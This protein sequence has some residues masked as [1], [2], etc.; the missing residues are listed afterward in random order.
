MARHPH[1]DSVLTGT[2]FCPLPFLQTSQ[3]RSDE[4][5]GLKALFERVFYGRSAS[6]EA[7]EALARI[8]FPGKKPSAGSVHRGSDR[9]RYILLNRG[10]TGIGKTRIFRQF[11]E[12]AAEQRIPVYEIHCYDV[13]GIPLKPFL[14]VIRE[15]LLDRSLEETLKE[16]YRHALEHVL[17]EWYTTSKEPDRAASIDPSQA[18]SAAGPLVARVAS[19][20]GRAA[21]VEEAAAEKIRVFDS[22]TQ[23]LFEITVER[24]VVILIHDLHWGDQVTIELL[25]YIGRNLELRNARGSF[26]PEAGAS[27]LAS[28]KAGWGVASD[29]RSHGA[30]ARHRDEAPELGDVRPVQLM[31]LANYTGFADEAH[32]PERSLRSLGEE[33]FAFHGEVRTLSPEESQRFLR[34]SLDGAP[35]GLTRI[36]CDAEGAEAAYRLTQGFPS[37]LHELLR[38]LFVPG[39]PRGKASVVRAAPDEPITALT[40]AVL[41]QAVGSGA[42]P[43]GAPERWRILNRRLESLGAEEIEL[44]EILSLARKPLPIESLS[45]VITRL[46][47]REAPA[48]LEQL[49]AVVAS[50]EEKFFLERVRHEFPL[51]GEDA[52]YYFRMADYALLLAS[53]IDAERTASIQQCLGEHCRDLLAAQGDEGA[54]EIFH[55]LIRGRRPVDA[56][57]FGIQAVERFTRA[58]SP[59]KAVLACDEILAVLNESPPRRTE[60]PVAAGAVGI[61]GPERFRSLRLVLERKSDLHLRLR[62]YAAAEKALVQLLGEEDEIL[63][64]HERVEVLLAQAEVVRAAGDPGRSLKLLSKAMRLHQNGDPDLSLRIHRELALASLDRQDPKRAVNFCLNGL[65]VAQKSPGLAAHASV[66]AILSRAH[67]QRGDMAHAV[68]NLHRALETLE[69]SGMDKH[70]TVEVLDDLGRVYLERGNYFRA[71]RYL[72]KS[73]EIKRRELDIIGL[74]RSYDELGKVYLRTDDELKT[75]EHLHRSLALK[76]RVGDVAGM[77]PT[78]GVLGELYFRLGQHQVALRYFK[79]EVENS[80]TLVDT[81]ALLDAFLHMGWV[82][83]ELGDLKQVEPL[84]RQV[85]ILAGE[86]KCKA[87]EA[88]GSRLRGAFEAIGRNWIESEKQLRAAIDGHARL[89]DRRREALSLLGLAEVKFYREAFD[90]SLKLA[91]KAQVIAEAQKAI[92]LQ[93][94]ALVMKGNVYRFLKGGSV[95]KAKEFLRRALELS[96]GLNDVR[97]LF[98]IFYSLAKVYHYDREFTEAGSFYAKAE[99]LLRRVAGGLDEDAAA[100]FLDDRRRKL[101]FE[102][103]ARFRKEAQSRSAPSGAVSLRDR[104]ATIDLNEK[105]AGLPDYKE[106]TTR[107]LKLHASVHALDFGERALAEALE[108]L[109]AE[110]GLLV[111]VQNRRFQVVAATGFG[112]DAASHGEFPAAQSLAEEAIRRGRVILQAGEDDEQPLDRPE[113]QRGGRYGRSLRVAG[114]LRRAI[115]VAPLSTADRIFGSIYVDRGETVGEFS[116]RDVVMAEGFAAHAGAAL[117]NRRLYEVAIREPVTGF[118][119]PSYFLDLLREAMRS[120]NLQSTGFHILGFHL[121]TLEGS[122]GQRAGGLWP[123][124]AEELAACL[125]H[126]SAVGWWAPIL[127]VLVPEP[128]APVVERVQ[129]QALQRL[130]ALLEGQV[131]SVQLAPE[132]RF[133][134]GASL[135]QELRSRLL[136]EEC[137]EETIGEIRNLLAKD[138]L[139]LKEAKKILEKHIIEST[140]RRTG[141]NITHAA[142]EL[143]IHRPQLSNLLKKYA[144]KREVFEREDMPL[145]PIDN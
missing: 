48:S 37:Y 60:R 128:N 103:A 76:E 77:N 18:A 19:V 29:E 142:R 28:A 5:I 20:V 78:L 32:Y 45:R 114:P 64:A 17:P 140:M 95:E 100:Q 44:L 81:R 121:P 8:E 104:P 59:E 82:Y 96:G 73:L 24:P 99:A 1:D 58:F 111:R 22:L 40:P 12:A 69:R 10:E 42:L 130:E 135:Y 2:S 25:R 13:E 112:A 63:S 55:H 133:A 36:A 86:F 65:K 62:E 118:F 35:E 61:V 79:R 23:L 90:E 138:N 72:Y 70:A 144:L 27:R 113:S 47:E 132:A 15:I 127:S 125:P 102:D 119:T 91:S 43:A 30:P 108:L 101:F 67:H 126:G 31:I 109:K 33:S 123:K 145:N 136:P 87:Q 83:L 53:R 134:D 129:A 4:E 124:V 88:E 57:R 94:L 56:I 3:F 137:D 34:H 110:R 74:A 122:L 85:S 115:L 80:Q 16:K 97:L 6:P 66:L 46:H 92:D 7:A 14:R 68:D 9:P 39:S 41:E 107:V 139:T 75:L 84:C 117:E 106:L 26:S 52:G 116:S 98:D 51:R 131:P 50:L 93:A 38:A 54:Y 21:P 143:G 49:E 11:R 120:S 89:S 105:P 141:G 71:A